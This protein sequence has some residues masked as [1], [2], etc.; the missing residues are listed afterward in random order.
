MIKERLKKNWLSLTAI[1]LATIAI[2]LTIIRIDPINFN[3]GSMVTLVVGLMGVCATIMVASQIIGLRTSEDKIK[4]MIEKESVYL[5]EIS[6]NNMIRALYRVEIIAITSI[7]QMKLWEVFISQIEKLESYATAL[8]DE[9]M[10]TETAN[11]LI[12]T[13][14]TFHFLMTLS[15]SDE[16]RLNKCVFALIKLV[17]NPSKL[18]RT[19]INQ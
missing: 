6:S 10:A 9:K 1:L 5:R 4:S 2:C 17:D 18:I 11:L 7:V 13:E 19:F 8:K 15:N 16:E 3:D 12:T 14:E